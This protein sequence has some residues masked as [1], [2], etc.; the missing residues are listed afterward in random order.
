[1]RT[2]VINRTIKVI[3]SKKAAVIDVITFVDKITW[4]N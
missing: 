4:D 1:M 3:W 2:E